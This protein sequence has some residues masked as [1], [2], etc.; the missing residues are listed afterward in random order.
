MKKI[1]FIFFLIT[2]AILQ[3]NVINLSVGTYNVKDK[4]PSI[5]F[6]GGNGLNN[7]S[8]IQEAIDVAKD[9]DII[10]VYENCYNENI[11]INKKVTIIGQKTINTIINGNSITNTV[12][13]TSSNINII[14]LKILNGGLNLGGSGIRLFNNNSQIS[15]INISNCILEDNN[16]GISLS[17]SNNIFI[18]NCTIINNSLNSILIDSSCNYIQLNKNLIINNGERVNDQILFSGGIF[19]KSN[20]NYYANI[21]IINCQ[22]I[23]NIGI[24]I[25]IEKV[26]GIIIKNNNISLN[27]DMGIS[28]NSVKNIDCHTNIINNNPFGIYL[29]QINGQ[30]NSDHIIIKDNLVSTNYEFNPYC[31]AIYIMNNKGKIIVN[32]NTLL[33]SVK[34][35]LIVN[36]SNIEILNNCFLNNDINAFFISYSFFT[37]NIWMKNLWERNRVCP[38]LI[39]GYIIY[40]Q[41]GFGT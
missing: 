34:G 13:V 39:Y 2:F 26:D 12:E 37:N 38:Y 33:N 36:S 7:Y 18:Y 28:L 8:S 31:S 22:I 41:Q 6:V 40:H 14:N 10:F 21:S 16:Y 32:N 9:G 3:L 29:C 27:S 23:K 5:I 24:G 30:N 4:E 25:Y 19:I 35:M 15:N 11:I 17:N 1:F 20:K